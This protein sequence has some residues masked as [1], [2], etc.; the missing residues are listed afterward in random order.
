MPTKPSAE[1]VTRFDSWTNLLVDVGSTRD[2]ASGLSF[3]R[4]KRLEKKILSALYEQN[5]TAARIVDRLVD[6]SLRNGWTLKKSEAD[7]DIDQIKSRCSDLGI[8]TALAQA[9]KWSRLYGGALLCLPTT[10][11]DANTGEVRKP[12]Q[13]L[14][15]VTRL[16]KPFVVPAHDAQPLA[17]DDVFGSPTYHKVLAYQIQGMSGQSINLHH[18]R[19]IPFEPVK[20]DPE[21]L[22]NTSPT[23][24]GPSVLDRAFESLSRYGASLQHGVSIMYVASLLSLNLEGYREE[25][26]K[27]DGRAAL[28]KYLADLFATLDSRGIMALDAKDKMTA[29]SLT[30]TGV[31]DVI[32]RNRDSVAA[33]AEMP[34][35]ILFNESPAGLNAGELSGPQEL[36]FSKC[37]S[38][39]EQ[40]LSP[41]LDRILEVAFEAWGQKVEEWE[42]EWLPLWTKSETGKADTAGKWATVDKTYFD[43][44]ADG[45]E[46]I[47]QRLVEGKTGALEF[48]APT[49]SNGNPLDLSPN[50]LAAHEAAGA[51]AAAPADAPTPA[52]QALTGV[53]I[54]S[55]MT[56]QQNLNSGLISYAQ[57]RG[58]TALSFPQ[59]RGR[60]SDLLGPPP[61]D[62]NATP[63][64][65]PAAPAP[66]PGTAPGAAPVADEPDPMNGPSDDPIP[67]DVVSP[68]E[69]A[70]KYRV[71]TRTITRM[72]ETAAIRYWGLGSHK[73]VSLSDI[74]KAARSHEQ[75]TG[76]R[77]DAAA[78]EFSDEC[79][80]IVLMAARHAIAA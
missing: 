66:A 25:Y 67:Q 80:V 56:I 6:D 58:I 69:A 78:I 70:A 35:E 76:D 46:I 26:K 21:T 2:K 37:G 22:R 18:T 61:A 15:T 47:R 10:D 43:M 41:P 8:D 63:G 30:T 40:D 60:E 72:M 45:E 23:G 19:C 65:A 62:Q 12:D 51:A 52:D 7:L 3:R 20:L 32:D 5:A 38:H 36:W 59:L 28:K 13:P 49:A 29:T 64:I 31:T 50:D 27:K 11:Y 79:A 48:S 42:T 14:G 24:W 16:Y 53:Q 9:D 44:G 17:W 71:S 34:R 55:G 74:A 1:A 4:R 68:Q 73:R 33:D 77:M 39:Q 54:T 57:A 75:P